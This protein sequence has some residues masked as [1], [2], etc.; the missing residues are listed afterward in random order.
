[1]GMKKMSNKELARKTGFSEPHISR[2][3]SGKTTP[4]VDCLTKMAIA[5]DDTVDAVLRY[6]VLKSAGVKK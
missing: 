3:L 1:M 5:L 4:S 2:V 6:I